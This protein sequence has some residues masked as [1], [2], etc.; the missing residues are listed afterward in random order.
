MGRRGSK[1]TISQPDATRRGLMRFL[2]DTNSHEIAADLNR[3]GIPNEAGRHWTRG[4]VHQ[5][6][7]NPK[8]V[9][10]NVYNRRS[11][12]LK[13]R[14]VVNPEPMWVRKDNAF[15]ALVPDGLFAEA[16][17]II[18]LRSHRYSDEEM[19][20]KLRC[21][22]LSEGRLSGILIDEM[23]DMPS[24][25]A[26]Q[27]R[28]GALYR[29]YALVGYTPQRDIAFIEINRALRELHRNHVDEIVGRLKEQGA[30]VRKEP[31]SEILVVNDDF[32]AALVIARCQDKGN[33]RYRWL[34]RLEHSH[35]SDITIAARM[36]QNNRDLL[37]YYLLPRGEELS[38][39]IR[40]APENPLVLDVYR[41]DNLNYLYE[42]SRRVRIGDAA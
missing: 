26:Y 16:A 6:L 36:A 18:E 14:R 20:E 3:R 17:K 41:F 12:K 30:A 15:P 10:A 25:S 38:R 37:D 4:G 9:G 11:F 39:K 31:E 7:I 33:G 1:G 19:L 32:T 28:F 5:I 24:S 2:R 21:L 27:S 22:Y 34:I 40:L 42:I 35:D 8:Y 29:A 23:D 13:Q